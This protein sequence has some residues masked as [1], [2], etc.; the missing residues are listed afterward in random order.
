VTDHP[1]C[2]HGRHTWRLDD[3]MR[4]GAEVLYCPQC[5]FFTCDACTKILPR[6]MPGE[7]HYPY[8]A[9]PT[10]TPQQCKEVWCGYFATEHENIA[11]AQRFSVDLQQRLW[12][13]ELRA[14][15][16]FFLQFGFTVRQS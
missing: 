11:Y 5:P 6:P 10:L 2:T 4:C 3:C 9:N 7:E 15:L 13:F 12:P 16:H 8:F 14:I 1:E